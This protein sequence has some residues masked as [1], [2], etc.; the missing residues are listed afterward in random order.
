LQKDKKQKSRDNPTD[1]ETVEVERVRS[2]AEVVETN[3][4]C[5]VVGADEP[6]TAAKHT[7]GT[8]IRSS[9]IRLCTTSI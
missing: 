5:A 3:R 9:W 8:A 1:A 2:V 7:V 6:A 4:N